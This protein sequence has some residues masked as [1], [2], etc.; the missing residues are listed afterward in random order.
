LRVLDQLRDAG[1]RIV[2]DDEAVRSECTRIAR[3]LVDDGR[4]IIG[5]LPA[6][7]RV[8][9]P[10]IAIQ[11]ARALHELLGRPVALVDAGGTWPVRVP[12][13]REAAFAASWIVDG[14]ALLTPRPAAGP[15]EL[16]LRLGPV[17]G[18]GDVAAF[19]VDLSG[20]TAAGEHV[21][22]MALCDAVAT[23]ARAGQTRERELLRAIADVPE[24][25]NLGVLLVGV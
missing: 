23:V 2:V 24:D 6:S 10:A 20:L 14:L 1:V 13:P 12:P 18:G 21:A 7:D 11:L 5:L 15:G 22:A 19:V 25:R 16:A 8:S 4:R 3:R 9:L 17:L